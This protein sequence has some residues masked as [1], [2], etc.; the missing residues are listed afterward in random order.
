LGLLP[1]NIRDKYEM[2]HSTEA[3]HL[4]RPE[5]LWKLWREALEGSHLLSVEMG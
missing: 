2:A 1:A 5:G 4:R 3:E